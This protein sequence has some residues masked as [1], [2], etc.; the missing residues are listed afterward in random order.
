MWQWQVPARPRTLQALLSLPAPPAQGLPNGGPGPTL[1]PPLPWPARGLGSLAGAW[2]SLPT[3]PYL[4]HP[5]TAEVGDS[6][7]QDLPKAL[8]GPQL[9]PP[10]PPS[11]PSPPGVPFGGPKGSLHTR[12][13]LFGGRPTR[14]RVAVSCTACLHPFSF[15]SAFRPRNA[16]SRPRLPSA[17]VAGPGPRAS[18]LGLSVAQGGERPLPQGAPHIATCAELSQGKHCTRVRLVT[19]TQERVHSGTTARG[20]PWA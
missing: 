18:H 17:G 19:W 6:R 7:T 2:V 12:C 20:V 8:L 3:H 4:L 5:S 1:T 15:F 13:P 9:S 11:L 10:N 16:S 14:L